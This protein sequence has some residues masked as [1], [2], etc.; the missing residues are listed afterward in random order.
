MKTIYLLVV[1]SFYNLLSYSQNGF[2]VDHTTTDL[3]QIPNSWIEQA[4]S[5]LHIAYNHTSHGSR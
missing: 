3:S 1:I 2:I 5:D 4:K